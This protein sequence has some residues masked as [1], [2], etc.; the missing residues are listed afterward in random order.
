MRALKYIVMGGLLAPVWGC[1]GIS[2][3]K[4]DGAA[5]AELLVKN[6]EGCAQAYQLKQTDPKRKYCESAVDVVR[7]NKVSAA[8]PGLLGI[9]AAPETNVHDDKHR[10]EAAKA[11]GQIGDASAVD[12]LI[13]ALDLAAGIPDHVGKVLFGYLNPFLR[14]GYE[15][16]AKRC[17]EV[18]VSGLLCGHLS[19]HNKYPQIVVRKHQHFDRAR[20][21]KKTATSMSTCWSRA[22][23][24]GSST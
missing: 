6:A 16:L 18:G 14:Y 22:R 2:D 17:A 21:A 24:G 5:C 23:P 12:G 3:C 10:R 8:V 7:K 15:R 20:P 13:S 19:G 1:S 4:E 11:L 9:L